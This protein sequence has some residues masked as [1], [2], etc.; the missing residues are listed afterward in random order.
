V[1]SAENCFVYI[2][3]S[4]CVPTR[5]YSGL[6]SNVDARIAAHN[7]GLSPHTSSGRPWK[8]VVAVQF[9][10]QE[11]AAEFE[12]YLKSGSGRAFAKTASPLNDELS[13]SKLALPQRVA[14]VGLL[15]SSIA[16]TVQQRT[17]RTDLRSVI[18]A[19]G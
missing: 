4:E 5:Y 13:R 3:Q 12:R 10:N 19:I 17:Q 14:T 11:R 16:S 8:L 2:L 1:P 18:F 6:T 7:A 9:A 15:W